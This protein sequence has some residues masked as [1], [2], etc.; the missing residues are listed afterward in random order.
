MVRR[1]DSLSA[2]GFDRIVVKADDE[3]VTKGNLDAM[4]MVLLRVGPLGRILREDPGLKVE[5]QLRLRAALAEHEN[6][7]VVALQAAT[8]VVTAYPMP[9][10]LQSVNS[11]RLNGWRAHVRFLHRLSLK[12]TIRYRPSRALSCARP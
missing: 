2:A 3:A 1:L 8:L 6:N 4:A 11:S 12:P 9:K 10:G 7:G 5:A